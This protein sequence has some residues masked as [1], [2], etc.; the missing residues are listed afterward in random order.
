VRGELVSIPT[1]ASER[2]WLKSI[3]SEVHQVS[4]F[5]G[6]HTRAIVFAFI[7]ID[8]P[9]SQQYIPRLKAIHKQFADQQVQVLG[10]YADAS[11]N[12]LSMARHAHDQDIPF[13]VLLDHELRLADLLEVTVVP[14]VVVLDANNEKRYQGAIDNQFKKRG[15][16]PEAT[17]HYLVESLEA[18]L[19]GRP[20]ETALVPASGCPLQR[21]NGIRV[22]DD[23]TFHRDIE[24]LIQK[25]CQ[26]CHRSGGAGPFELITFD[27]VMGNSDSIREVVSERRMPPWH[28]FL[29]PQ[30]GTLANDKS[31]SDEEIAALL[32]W[33]AGRAAKGDPADAPQPRQWPAPDAWGI[34]TPDYV[35]QIDPPFRVPKHGVL[36][37]QFFRV[38][39]DF[40]EDRWFRAVEIKPGNAEVVH[41]IT[42]HLIE[43]RGRTFDSF[44]GM[45]SLYG[46]NAQR[47]RL[48]NDYLPGDT[49]N[50]KTHTSDQA[51]RIPKH[52]DLVF[53]IHY[54]PNNRNATVDQ[55]SV[56]FI[57]ADAPPQHEVF[58]SVFRRPVG[59]FR[60]PP[61]DPHFRMED[62]YYFEHDV[63]LDT[64]RPHFHL[65]GKSYRLEMIE[66]DEATDEIVNRTT[67]L[68]VPVYDFNW[69]RTY[70]LATPLRIPAGTE[71]LSVAHF[72]NSEM[73]PNNPDP[74]AT[75]TWGEG[76][77]DEMF[78]T[79][80]KYRVVPRGDSQ[81]HVANR[82]TLEREPKGR[83]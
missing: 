14:E 27:D 9:V 60:I 66:R 41:H 8:C 36:E 28:G 7:G 76:T 1:S 82:Q 74:S 68:S 16:L 62:T 72:D 55:S 38:K 65:R 64:I 26:P 25:N 42:L 6:P 2:P 56:G 81:P 44:L 71:L 39:L 12:V 37:Y 51:V 77:T 18:V 10:I 73:N 49:Y 47:A 32:G 53:E 11:V 83:N 15:R 78:S 46:L 54:T 13:P 5:Q 20:V 23:L 33:L 59:R 4:D 48:L 34:G 43:A 70:E 31:M 17:Q 21:S 52:S 63:E 40:P 45:A 58:T 69:Q 67:I 61:R 22:R 80:F 3:Y 75:V 30:F 57:W 24:P 19:A 29:N 79:R 50:A 35:Y